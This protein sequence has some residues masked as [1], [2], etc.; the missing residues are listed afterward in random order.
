M[1]TR[2]LRGQLSDLGRNLSRDL[3][4]SDVKTDVERLLGVA[5]LCRVV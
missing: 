1:E 2:G 3:A 5:N 4:R